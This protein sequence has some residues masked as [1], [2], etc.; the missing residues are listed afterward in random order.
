MVQI[1]IVAIRDTDPPRSIAIIDLWRACLD[2]EQ[3]LH[4]TSV[5]NR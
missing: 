3:C 2:S 4:R 5:S 1:I